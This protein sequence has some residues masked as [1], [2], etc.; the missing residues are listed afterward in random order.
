ME[1]LILFGPPG[2]GKG[3]QAARLVERYGWSHLAT[4]DMFREALERRDP[5]A[6][7]AQDIMKAGRLVPDGLIGQMVC[8]KLE[9][10]QETANSAGVILDGYPR[11]EAQ[12]GDLDEILAE[13]SIAL[14]GVLALEVEDEI[15]VKRLAGRRSCP[16]CGR[17]YNL[18]FDPPQTEGHCDSDGAELVCRPDDNEQT[19]RERLR[20]YGEQTH[21]V[22]EIYRQRGQ[23][24]VVQGDGSAGEVLEQ[25]AGI[26]DQ[27]AERRD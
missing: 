4:G 25:I 17:T 6:L 11:N 10:L 13:R 22:L 21:A 1:A 15:L 16:V 7:E 3:T 14:R 26:V 12:V 18:H 2:S 5:V 19:I 24:I 27:W 23:L 9:W 8:Q 20:V